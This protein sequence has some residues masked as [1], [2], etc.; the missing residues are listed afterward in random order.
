M[1]NMKNNIKKLD[2]EFYDRPTLDVAR[3]LLGEGLY[4]YDDGYN[5]FNIETGKRINIDYAEEARD[6][7]WRFNLVAK[8]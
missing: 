5:D 2:R 4:L 8:S 7:M 3:D 1:I 6:F